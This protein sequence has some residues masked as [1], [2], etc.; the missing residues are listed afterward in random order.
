M[1]KSL[2]V[3]GDE[4]HADLVSKLKTS[5]QNIQ[6]Y[7]RAPS[8]VA[9]RVQLNPSIDMKAKFLYNCSLSK[10]CSEFVYVCSPVL[11]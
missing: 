10:K 11:L 4:E 1:E 8:H 3:E 5:T 6:T 2:L 9:I 7:T